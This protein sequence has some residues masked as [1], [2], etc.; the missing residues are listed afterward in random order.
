MDGFAIAIMPPLQDGDCIYAF[1]TCSSLISAVRCAV[2]PAPVP[3][4]S[5]PAMAVAA[6][7]LGL[8][9]LL[10]VARLRR[11]PDPD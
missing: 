10:G 4:L 2:A 5:A 11:R 7:V 8:I 1:D 3:A 9:A 6:G